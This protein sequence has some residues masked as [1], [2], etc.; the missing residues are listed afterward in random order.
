MKKDFSLLFRIPQMGDAILIHDAKGGLIGEGIEWFT[1]GLCSHVELYIGGGN[2]QTIGARIDGVRV[3]SLRDYFH[4]RFTVTVR[5]IKGITVTRAAMIKSRAW[6]M[7]EKKVPYG[8]FSYLGFILFC[9][10]HKMGIN[11]MWLP[12]PTNLPGFKVCSELYD[13]C[14]KAAG[15]DL[16]PKIGDG[17][18]TPQHIMESDLLETIIEV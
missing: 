13:F 9:S 17:C 10:L 1:N 16:F 14:A 8:F 5:R 12:N 18:V 11:L 2:A 3:H 15:F 6:W 4:D 7:V